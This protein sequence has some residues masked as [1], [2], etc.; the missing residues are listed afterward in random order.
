MSNAVETKTPTIDAKLVNPFVNAVRDVF[1]TMVKVHATIQKPF[2]KTQPTPTHS[3]CGIIGFTGSVTGAVILSFSNSAAEKLV[4]S[5]A[6]M[7]MEIGTTD[8]ADAI[9]ELAN[10]VAGAAKS[11]L[12]GLASISVPSVVIGDGFTVTNMSSVPCLVIP[13]TCPFGDFAV[14]VC[15]KKNP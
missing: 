12:G 1:Q 10:M 13:C 15:I 14:E 11:N 9:G 8:F 4:E 2:L 6:G 7:K 3:I 5:F